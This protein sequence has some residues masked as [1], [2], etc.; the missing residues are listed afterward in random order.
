MSKVIKD[1]D[2]KSPC[3]DSIDIFVFS[4]N[5]DQRCTEVLKQLQK[6]HKTIKKIVK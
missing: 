5:K 3:F 4:I 6:F 2:I 1:I